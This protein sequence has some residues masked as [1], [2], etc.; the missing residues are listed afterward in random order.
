[1]N[2]PSRLQPVFHFSAPMTPGACDAKFDS[3]EDLAGR[4]GIL[5]EQFSDVSKFAPPIIVMPSGSEAFAEAISGHNTELSVLIVPQR[6]GDATATLLASLARP[7]RSRCP[8]FALI[9]AEIALESP[10]DIA[11]LIHQAQISALSSGKTV[12][13]ARRTGEQDR[14]I[15][16]EA[17]APDLSTNLLTVQA[18]GRA[19]DSER[20]GVA[21]EMG[22]LYCA[23][24]PIVLS[25][26]ALF[27]AARQYTTAVISSCSSAMAVAS[28]RDRILTPNA[29]FLSL[30]PCQQLV[31]LLAHRPEKLLLHTGGKLFKT[32]D[33]AKIAVVSGLADFGEQ[34]VEIGQECAR[35]WGSERLISL[36]EDTR[37]ARLA[38]RPGQKAA[39]APS[40][41]L[42]HWTIASGAAFAKAGGDLR[43][44]SAGESLK[45][46]PG[47][48]RALTNIGKTELIVYEISMPAPAET[49]EKPVAQYG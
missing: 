37:I 43:T 36:D 4:T 32:D 8:I 10:Q 47:D 24:G 45:I 28:R 30:V 40:K 25:E 33:A 38:V 5:L 42:V 11:A 27:D 2:N 22:Q 17:S 29:R 44:L 1:M 16:F 12:V 6:T 48:K 35:P 14:D 46:A 34:C 41:Q 18:S 21:M 49:A 7:V 39:C 31:E 3:K 19:D 15:A 9:P 26:T 23:N 20:F 13:F